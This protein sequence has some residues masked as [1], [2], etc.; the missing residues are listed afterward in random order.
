MRAGKFV[1]ILVG[2]CTNSLALLAQLPPA[3]AVPAP[4]TASLSAQPPAAAPLPDTSLAYFYSLH[5]Y[6][7]LQ[8][9]VYYR[10]EP[11]FSPSHDDATFYAL[12]GLVL[13]L[14]MMRSA[15]SKYFADLLRMFAQSTL[16]QKSLREQL[17]QNRLAS[18]LLNIFFCLSAGTF[19]YQLAKYQQW[20]PLHRQHLW[21]SWLACIGFVAAVYLVKY[22]STATSGWVFGFHEL[23]E[24]YNFMVFLVNKVV[25]I[26][27]LP[28]SIILALGSSGLQSVFVV[29]SIAGL[30]LLFIYRYVLAIPML[31][32]HVRA[33]PI[34]FFLYL[35]AFEIIPVL[36]LYKVVLSSVQ[37]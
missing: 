30:G 29:L 34:H 15:F 2:L 28:A 23:A 10:M 35:C 16:R 1:G 24:Q 20:L 33:I 5:P 17:L 8:A 7:P 36:V 4:D 25:G 11:S 21:W 9:D 3:G 12:A 27:L 37:Q 13:I 32:Q 14:A 19:L 31:R 26:L 18:L 6:L 22:I